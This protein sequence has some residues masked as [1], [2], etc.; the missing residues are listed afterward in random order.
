MP[1]EGRGA[2]GRPCFRPW[3]HPPPAPSLRRYSKLSDPANWLRINASN[4]QVTTAAALDRE[5]LYIR[6]N[7]YEATFLAADNGAP[8][9]VL[10]AVWWGGRGGGR[11]EARR[12]PGRERGAAPGPGA[13]RHPGPRRSWCPRP[14]LSPHS[15][16]ASVILPGFLASSC[17][18]GHP[19]GRSL[20]GGGGARDDGG[21][22]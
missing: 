11:G 22:A 16:K 21:L 6:N 15:L 20:M 17:P 18:S 2:P 4:G 14:S 12:R 10:R 8:R 5:S 1:P 9:R 19:H 7:V 3:L 13:E